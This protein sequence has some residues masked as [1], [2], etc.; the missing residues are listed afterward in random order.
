VPAGD[1]QG[2]ARRRRPFRGKRDDFCPLMTRAS[3]CLGTSHAGRPF[4]SQANGPLQQASKGRDVD[5]F[6]LNFADERAFRSSDGFSFAA[7]LRH[8]PIKFRLR[9]LSSMILPSP[10][11]E[12]NVRPTR[13]SYDEPLQLTPLASPIRKRDA[14][15]RKSASRSSVRSRRLDRG[16][17]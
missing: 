1:F 12:G 7:S 15:L 9:H 4:S 16:A 6:Q 3:L 8:K 10:S 5:G 2:R 17:F 11:S 13:P 14:P